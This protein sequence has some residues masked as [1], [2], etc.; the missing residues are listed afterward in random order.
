MDEAVRLITGKISKQNSADN[1]DFVCS[2]QRGRSRFFW[3]GGNLGIQ[4]PYVE[5]KGI[6]RK[7]ARFL[8]HLLRNQFDKCDAIIA[9]NQDT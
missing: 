2:K 1:Q 9:D 3:E 7:I 5:E 8:G 6:V 4:D